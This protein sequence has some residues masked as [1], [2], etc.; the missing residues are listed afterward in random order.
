MTP[1]LVLTQRLTQD[2]RTLELAAAKLGW[3]VHRACNMQV[4]DG[5][6]DPTVFG[7]V[8]FCDILAEHLGLALLETTDGWLPSLPYRY[9]RREVQLMQHHELEYVADRR[10]IK[11]ANDKV[12]QAGIFLHG[13]HVPY[14][15]IQPTAPVLVSEVVEFEVEVRCHILDREVQTS[16]IYQGLP[17]GS[18]AEQEGKILEHAEAWME[19]F[20]D[21]PKVE[22]PSAIVVD[23]GRIPDIGWVVI[24]ANQAYASGVYAGGFHSKG[25]RG[26]DP[27]RTL[28][29]I[30]RSAQLIDKV[31]T[32]DLKWVRPQG[33]RSSAPRREE[34]APSV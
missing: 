13:R 12:F 30:H 26:A 16:S 10:F 24:E 31:S 29:V 34:C 7:D 21:D 15:Q 23:I 6:K 14:R 11:P 25:G 20:L 28:R 2:S 17:W 3:P 32:E 9:L 4:P 27:E 8:A 19:G 1:S 18:T 5:I 33:V 22:L